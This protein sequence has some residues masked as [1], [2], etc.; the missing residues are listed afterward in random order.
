M[1]IVFFTMSPI[2][3]INSRSIYTDLLKVFIQKGHKITI[4]APTYEKNQNKY[5]FKE[6]E[7]YSIIKIYVSGDRNVNLIRKALNL[8]LL[9]YLYINAVKKFLKN[10]KFDLILYSTPPITLLKAVKYMRKR[11]NCKTYLMLKDIFPQNAVDLKLLSKKGIGSIVYH[12]FRNKEKKLYKVS[13][14]IGCM[15]EANID[16]LIS[17]NTNLKLE[18]VGLCVN[19]I[20]PSENKKIEINEVTKKYNLPSNKLL[21]FYGGNFGKPQGVRFLADLLLDNFYKEDRFFILC[22]HGTEYN[23]IA[24][25]ISKH[26]SANVLLIEG[27]PK[28]EYDN[29]L[30]AC[31]VGLLFLD[32]RF[33]IPNFPSRMLPYME[34]SKP[35]LAFTDTNTDV[36][37]KITDGEFGWWSASND[38]NKASKLLDRIIS[39]SEIE[40][41]G[42]NSR[43]YLEKY[44]CSE[45]SY[46]QIM[47]KVN[48][49][50]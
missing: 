44:Y 30:S 25:L 9:E 50:D 28:T 29:L 39:E 6:E 2:I 31:D 3:N 26:P 4:I 11:N 14:Y 1:N 27:L 40:M 49:D 32:S 46:Q 36:G 33:T 43:K 15:S 20:Q 47:A 34:H 10:E 23:I 18:N 5:E 16:Y 41:I 17:H 22:G 24:S 42:L 37:T 45:I 35:I 13:D 7:D 48:G 12:Y 21:L 8:F 19:S 38:L